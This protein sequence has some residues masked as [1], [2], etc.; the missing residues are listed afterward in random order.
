[1]VDRG[2]VKSDRQMTRFIGPQHSSP[3]GLDGAEPPVVDAGPSPGGRVPWH[4]LT[5]ASLGAAMLCS[6]AVY[7]SDHAAPAHAPGF[8]ERAEHPLASGSRRELAREYSAIR[9]ADTDLRAPPI[10]PSETWPA[11]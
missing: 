8:L 11:Q 3:F 6:W 5:V 2:A 1:M 4:V 9:P 10:P 7:L